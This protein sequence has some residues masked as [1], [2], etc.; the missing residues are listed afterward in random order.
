MQGRLDD[1]IAW[2]SGLNGNWSAAN[3][4]A[5]HLWWHLALFHTERGEYGAGLDIY[6]NRLRDLDS[7]LMQLMPDYY[8]DI[9]NDTAL[10]QR[11]ELR[12]VDIGDR[13]QPIADLAKARI[14][15]H[16]SP[17]TSAHC[18]LALAAAGRFDEANDLIRQIRDFVAVDN[19]ALGS[20]YALAV[21]PAS[22]AA[23]AYRKGEYQRVIDVMLP[24][25]RNLWQMGGSHAQRDLFFQ[26]LV[27]SASKTNRRD[28]L[29]MLLDEIGAIGFE[30]L[31]ERSSYVDAVAM[32]H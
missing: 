16:F 25:R 6:D 24:A 18:A 28:T 12:E 8:V 27:D 2:L 13:W 11:L 3:H 21:L 26:L 22:E 7:P 30:H 1:G 5:H 17:F 14:G 4:I 29:N 23:V 19:G 32:T 10:L 9:Q 15:N 31:A 20:R